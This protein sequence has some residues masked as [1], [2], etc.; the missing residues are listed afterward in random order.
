MQEKLFCLNRGGLSIE[1]LTHLPSSHFRVIDM[2]IRF[3]RI[4]II[5]RLNFGEVSFRE[6][7]VE[8]LIL[9]FIL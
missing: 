9:A 2:I 7:F 4:R 1:N 8:V 6:N 3:T 5:F